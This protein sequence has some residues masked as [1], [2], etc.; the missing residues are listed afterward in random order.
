[1]VALFHFYILADF[2]GKSLSASWR[3]S[4]GSARCRRR[5]AGRRI[6]RGIHS[7]LFRLGLGQRD[8]RVGL[9]PLGCAAHALFV[10]LSP[11]P[12]LYNF[13]TSL[14][15]LCY[16]FWRR[17]EHEQRRA[18][19]DRGRRKRLERSQVS[20]DRTIPGSCQGHRLAGSSDRL[21]ER[22]HQLPDHSS[23]VSRQGPCFAAR[24]DHDGQ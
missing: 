19:H 5:R 23:Q 10:P 20:V 2:I 3:R 15:P 13:F 4:C 7:V 11:V 24:L 12:C 6:R 14:L 16:A 21:V 22:A 1:L 8:Q 9:S 18:G 17:R